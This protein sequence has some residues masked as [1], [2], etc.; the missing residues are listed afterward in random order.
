MGG[1]DSPDEC[2]AAPGVIE[3]HLLT[4]AFDPLTA[5]T[6]GVKMAPIIS[7]S[8]ADLLCRRSFRETLGGFPHPLSPHS[9]AR[10][11]QLAADA[12]TVAAENL[13]NSKPA[14]QHES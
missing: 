12:C 4:A 14:I 11:D 10:H 9:A 2:L 5:D 8:G 13:L 7:E 1:V 6:E 3:L